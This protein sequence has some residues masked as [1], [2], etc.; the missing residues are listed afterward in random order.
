[1]TNNKVEYEAIL[2]GLKV[3]KAL[4]AKSAL[5]K[6]NLKFVIGKINGEFKAKERRLQKYLKLTN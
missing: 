5:L 4:G 2:T 3:T 1:M 6:S